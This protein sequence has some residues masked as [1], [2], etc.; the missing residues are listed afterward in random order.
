MSF[1]LYFILHH[2]LRRPN[3]F[4][5]EPSFGSPRSSLRLYLLYMDVEAEHR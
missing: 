5:M 2:F 1:H 4:E 3:D